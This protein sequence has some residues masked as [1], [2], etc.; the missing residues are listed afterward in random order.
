MASFKMA[1]VKRGK[2]RRCSSSNF[3]IGDFRHGP[4]RYASWVAMSI[5][6]PRARIRLGWRASSTARRA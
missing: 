3:S 4:S 6:H 5:H 1:R 2:A